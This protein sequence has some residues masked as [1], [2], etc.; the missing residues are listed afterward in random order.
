MLF[1]QLFDFMGFLDLVESV[2]VWLDERLGVIVEKLN[3]LILALHPKRRV[4]IIIFEN[5]RFDGH[6]Q[7]IIIH[8][9]T[10]LSELTIQNDSD[11]IAISD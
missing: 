4:P 2:I 1:F 5:V 11:D 10:E 3:L 6:S 8:I 9:E 7:L